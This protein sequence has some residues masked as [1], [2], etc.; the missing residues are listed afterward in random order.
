VNLTSITSYGVG[1]DGQKYDLSNAFFRGQ[2]ASFGFGAQYTGTDLFNTSKTK[3][4][5]QE[6]RL[7][8]ALGNR[9]DWLAGVF[10]THENSPHDNFYLV[11]DPAT[12]ESPGNMWHGQF[13]LKFTE[14]AAF[15][16]L[17]WKITDRF[18]IQFGGRESHNRQSFESIV[19]GPLAPVLLRSPSPVITPPTRSEGTFATYLFTPRYKLS[20]DAM[21]YARLASGYR[22]GGPNPNCPAISALGVLCEYKAD[23][24]R[25][26][27][28]GFKADLFDR[29]ASVDASVYYIDWDDIQISASVSNQSFFQN[30]GGAKSEGAEVSLTFRPAR[31]TK[32]GG[33]FAYNNAEITEPFP[34]NSP[35]I[36]RQ[37]DRLPLSSRNSANLSVDQDIVLG[38]DVTAYVGG[39]MVYVG[40]RASTFRPTAALPQVLFPSYTKFDVRAGLRLRT[41]TIAGFV[42]NVTDRRAVL[43]N[44]AVY[45]GRNLYIQPRTFGVNVTKEF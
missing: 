34:A 13:P 27:E 41:Y 10:Y 26:Y 36:T 19:T 7:D 33:W 42:T 11:V 18:D 31:G 23:N 17:T 30:A 32:I 35:V 40:D 25:N 43:D 28:V 29:V 1:E 8:G 9:V 21:I 38:S 44:D 16:D 12:G 14:Y 20:D 37:G 24:A 39:T 15:G 3:K 5:T 45:A 22:P 2:Q 4:F 6:V